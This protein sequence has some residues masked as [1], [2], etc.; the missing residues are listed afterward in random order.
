MKKLI[1]MTAVAALSMTAFGAMAAPS[2]PKPG[3]I[4]IIKSIVADE[5]AEMNVNNPKS[6]KIG[7]DKLFVGNTQLPKNG[8]PIKVIVPAEDASVSKPKS[9]KFV[10][11]VQTIASGPH[12]PNDGKIGTGI[13]YIAKGKAKSSD[14]KGGIHIRFIA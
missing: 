11:G 14:Q 8:D 4:I 5:A 9:G 10:T 1:T 13:K 7:T 12:K 6:G 2:K 3:D